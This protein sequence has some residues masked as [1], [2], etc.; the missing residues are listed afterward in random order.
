MIFDTI[1][2]VIIMQIQ[3]KHSNQGFGGIGID[4]TNFFNVLILLKDINMRS[5]EKYL[6]QMNF[7]L[8]RILQLVNKNLGMDN[9]FSQNENY[10]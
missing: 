7:I 5:K 2:K 4:N 6:P 1:E 10:F 3:M 8:P 9:V